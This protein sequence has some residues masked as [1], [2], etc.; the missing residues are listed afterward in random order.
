MYNDIELFEIS[1]IGSYSRFKDFEINDH[2][3]NFFLMFDDLDTIIELYDKVSDMN[4]L[5]VKGFS[6]TGSLI[7]E[8]NIKDKLEYHVVMSNN[9]VRGVIK[10]HVN[11]EE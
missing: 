3:Q 5:Q 11:M 4:S 6:S 7:A 8:Y 1:G 10:G 2:Y 9:L